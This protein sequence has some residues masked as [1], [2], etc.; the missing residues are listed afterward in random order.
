MSADGQYPI[1]RMN[2]FERG[3]MVA[4]P[5][6]YID[7]G[8]EEFEKYK[9]EKG[10]ILFNRTNSI[11]LVGKNGIFD[12]EGDYVFASY[13][14]RLRT[15]EKMNPYYLNYYMNS[16][17]A[18]SVF[19]AIA[20]R[21]ASQA[22]INATNLKSVGVPLPPLKEQKKIVS[23]LSVVDSKIQKEEKYKDKLE[24]LKKGLMQKL[25][26]GKVRVKLD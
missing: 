9:L 21:G 18:E 6:K 7:L 26:T 17:Y 2:N 10:D 14:I 1:F 19:S 23:I 15:N 16:Y 25:L 13:L 11:D 12:L 5:I 24:R 4:S 3:C 8:E 20:T 22:N